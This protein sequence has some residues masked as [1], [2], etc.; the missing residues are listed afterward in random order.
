M[1][2][3]RKLILIEGLFGLTSIIVLVLY[4]RAMFS[5]IYDK[6]EIYQPPWPSKAVNITKY[7]D[8]VSYET[9][10]PIPRILC[11]ITTHSKNRKVSIDFDSCALATD[12]NYMYGFCY[13][14]KSEAVR[15]T[16]G[17]DCDVFLIMTSKS[18]NRESTCLLLPK[19]LQ[20]LQMLEESPFKKPRPANNLFWGKTTSST[21][22]RRIC[23]GFFFFFL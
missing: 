5:Y 16:W 4:L 12:Q 20:P 22:L 19:L 18:T 21:I 1:V 13:L 3:K 9:V 23:K 2:R 8:F 10:F 11:W 14:Q 17:Q 6:Y 15:L 7:Q